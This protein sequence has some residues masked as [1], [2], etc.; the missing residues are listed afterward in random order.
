MNGTSSAELGNQVERQVRP[1]AHVR[2]LVL[3]PADL[4]EVGVLGDLRLDLVDGTRVQPLEPGDREP[5]LGLALLPL[6]EQVPRD[7]ARAEQQ[8]ANRLRVDPVVADHRLGTCPT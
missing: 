2:R 7:P 3:D 5:A 6:R 4:L 1:R 8:D